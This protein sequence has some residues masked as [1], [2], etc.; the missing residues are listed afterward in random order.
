MRGDAFAAFVV[1]LES[2]GLPAHIIDEQKLAMIVNEERWDLVP[3][4]LAWLI[5]E[6]D[7]V[8]QAF[9]VFSD[10]AQKCMANLRAGSVKAA[11]K[12]ATEILSERYRGVFLQAASVYARKLS[13]LE[14]SLDH[15]ST[16]TLAELESLAAEEDD[17][18]ARVAAISMKISDEI[19]RREAKKGAKAKDEK[20]DPVRQFAR[21]L[22]NDGNYP[23]RRQAVFAIKADVLDYART[24][25]G[26]SL[27]E[28]QAEKTIDGWLKEMPD[29][30]SL[31]GRK[32][33]GGR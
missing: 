4:V 23:S 2:K 27:S 32:D 25:D 30:D 28:Q 12:R 20:L 18:S 22:A 6:D 33:G 17:L 15:L 21:K 9:T 16:L 1:I 31:F 19:K 11:N 29:A 13:T 8:K 3:L 26:V 5:R 14:A 10:A 7:E 24:L